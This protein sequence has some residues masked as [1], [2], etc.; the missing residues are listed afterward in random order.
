MLKALA[1][2]GSQIAQ[3]VLS[4]LQCRNGR[5]IAVR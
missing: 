1:T 2:E 5:L 4:R 3:G